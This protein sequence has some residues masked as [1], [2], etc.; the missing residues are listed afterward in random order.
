MFNESKLTTWHHW[1]VAVRLCIVNAARIRRML[2]RCDNPQIGIVAPDFIAAAKEAL[3][4]CSEFP[5]INLP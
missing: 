3:A 2:M 4:K 5:P 1:R